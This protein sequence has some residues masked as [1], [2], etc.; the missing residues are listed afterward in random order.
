MKPEEAKKRA[1]EL[2]AQMT[3][4]EKMSQMLNE[5]PAIERLGIP[6]YNWW[7]E[8]LHGVGRSGLSTVFPQPIGLAASFDTE[9]MKQVAVAF[10]DEARAKYNEFSSH[11][12]RDCYQGLTYWCPNIN[13][14]RDPRWGRGHETYGE[15]PFL[16]GEMAVAFVD[17]MQGDQKEC[18]KLDA[19]LKHFVAHSGPEGCRHGFDAKVS[20]KDL[21]ETYLWAF[22]YCIQKAKPAAVMGAYNTVNGE[23][24]CAS[25]HLL[26]DIL[27]DELG[28]EG[29]VVSDCGAICDLHDFHHITEGK[30]Q[31]SAL[32]VNSGCELNCGDAYQGLVVAYE[33]G[34]VTEDAI[35]KAVERLFQTR[36]ELGM[37]D[38]KTPWDSLGYDDVA[39]PAHKQLAREMAARS[40]VVLKNNGIL[41]LNKEI[42]SIAVIGPNANNRDVL[43][44][45]Y[46]GTPDQW[47]TVLD[48]VQRNVGK[49]VRVYYTKG[50]DVVARD[51][52]KWEE[53]TF[54]E[55]LILA[56][57]ADVV[58]F[59]CGLNPRLEGEEGDAFN[60]DAGGDK[61]SLDL[62]D[63]QK[64]LFQALVKVGTPIITINISGSALAFHEIA[65]QSAAIVQA[66]YPG[67]QGGDA[68][69]D[70]LSGAVNPSG[71]LPVTFYRSD[72]DL[73]AFDDYHM[74]GRTYRY[75][76]GDPLYPFGYGL[77]YS[78]FCYQ[79]LS[80]EN[81]GDSLLFH[82]QVENVSDRD[83]SEVIQIYAKCMG[84]ADGV[85][86]AKLVGFRRV[87]IQAG[88]VW[89]GDITVEKKIL[90]V[91]DQE[92]KSH[93]PQ[94]RIHFY[95]GGH[96]PDAVS[97]RLSDTMCVEAEISL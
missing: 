53:N 74:K 17:G 23:P 37:C 5:A 47:I 8:G 67:E 50:C 20:K 19:T 70:V 11:G 73:P 86:N 46:N 69:F 72:D 32:A 2:V 21:Y 80:I 4:G 12:S 90:Y 56:E 36:F 95:V 42:K 15:D 27:R 82:I 28:F 77:S 63:S 71:R 22:A 18:R 1:K 81:Q 24:C 60:S 87:D 33:M 3:L 38:E 35:S 29:Y 10:S 34:L 25:K 6:A 89:H 91:T 58:L 26:Q 13:I 9:L 76:Q 96:Q 39:T 59:C 43:L 75:F 45:N 14:F 92:G 41:P 97:C 44:G 84:D 65:E 68:I 54:Q 57:K 64:K 78:R 62:P 16:T 51:V 31:S 83:G 85:P 52:P 66:W 49:D 61:I 88:Q 93:I 55:A 30:P 94:G 48:G 40:I 7:N 79:N